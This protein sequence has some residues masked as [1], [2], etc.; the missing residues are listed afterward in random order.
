MRDWLVSQLKYLM[1]RGPVNEIPSTP[2]QVFLYYIE[3]FRVTHLLLAELE[4]YYPQQIQRSKEEPEVYRPVLYEI[5]SADLNKV[6]VEAAC[7]AWLSWDHKTLDEL[8]VPKEQLP[9]N[10]SYSLVLDY[11]EPVMRVAC[12]ITGETRA[13]EVQE[14][15]LPETHYMAE[16]YALQ[17]MRGYFPTISNADIEAIKERYAPNSLAVKPLP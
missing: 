8:G 10:L 13:E 15:I 4:K 1:Q 6:R 7:C 14:N 3:R 17:E 16:Q 12:Y 11:P 2:Y 5:T 9:E